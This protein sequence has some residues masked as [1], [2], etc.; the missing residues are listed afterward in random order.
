MWPRGPS[1]GAPRRYMVNCR[2]QPERLDTARPQ[3]PEI[4]DNFWDAEGKRIPANAVRLQAGAEH[5][6]VQRTRHKQDH[7]QNG[8]H[9]ISVF[10]L[11][12][13]SHEPMMER[14]RTRV[15]GFIFESQPGRFR[16]RLRVDSRLKGC[17]AAQRSRV[18]LRRQAGYEIT[19]HGAFASFSGLCAGAENGSAVEP[20]RAEHQRPF[21]FL[22]LAGHTAADNFDF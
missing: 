14:L 12:R 13:L 17:P 10:F 15:S 8:A 5:D 21:P 22:D 1:L 19:A 3:A 7:R 4:E 18:R 9:A 11:I 6:Q 2:P 20:L 16:T